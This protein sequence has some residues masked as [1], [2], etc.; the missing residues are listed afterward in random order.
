MPQ[1]NLTKAQRWALAEKLAAERLPLVNSIQKPAVPRT[2]LYSR[3]IKRLLDIV[4]S[5]VALIVSLP[6]NLVFA[7]ITFADVGRPIFFKQQ[8]VG[9]E[10]KTFELVKLRNMTND[11]DERGELLPAAQRV[12]KFGRFMRKTSLD[13]LLNF[14]S[15]FKGDMSLIGPRPLVPEYTQRYSERH[16]MR[17]AVRPGL[18]CPPRAKMDHAWTWDEQFEND[19]WYIENISFATD[20]IMIKNLLSFAFDRKNSNARSTTARKAFIGY[21]FDGKA[22]GLNDLSQ[23]FIDSMQAERKRA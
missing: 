22:I 5:G 17:L 1:E 16:K 23:E 15:V 10:G 19:I 7:L 9:K 11:R 8:R 13:E 12:T 20:C 2:T 6:F 3:Y 14:W 18:E 21:D 4:V